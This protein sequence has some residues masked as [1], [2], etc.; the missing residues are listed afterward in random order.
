M[1]KLLSEKDIRGLGKLAGTVYGRTNQLGRQDRRR[2]NASSLTKRPVKAKAQSNCAFT[3]GK[4]FNLSGA[5]V[6]AYETLYIERPQTEVDTTTPPYEGGDGPVQIVSFALAAADPGSDVTFTLPAN[7][8]ED[9]LILFG[10][11]ELAHG[12]ED[13]DWRKRGPI[14]LHESDVDDV[15]NYDNNQNFSYC[16]GDYPLGAALSALQ[17]T[18]IGNVGGGG[19]SHPVPIFVLRNVARYAWSDLNAAHRIAGDIDYPGSLLAEQSVSVTDNTVDGIV[20]V[21]D[22]AT[23]PYS[24]LEVL[25]RSSNST[26]LDSTAPGILISTTASS[27]G[28]LQGDPYY[29]EPGGWVGGSTGGT[30]GLT[31]VGVMTV[32]QNATSGGSIT[33]LGGSAVYG[34]TTP[35]DAVDDAYYALTVSY[36]YMDGSG[37]YTHPNRTK[38]RKNFDTTPAP[39]FY[40]AATFVT[41][42]MAESHLWLAAGDNTSDP[43]INLPPPCEPM[44]LRGVPQ[45]EPIYDSYTG[46]RGEALREFRDKLRRNVA[47]ATVDSPFDLSSTRDYVVHGYTWAWVYVSNPN[48]RYAG[49]PYMNATRYRQ[50]NPALA[51]V[52]GYVGRYYR[53]PK[54]KD[55]TDDDIDHSQFFFGRSNYLYSANSG[56]VRI[57]YASRAD[58]P[59]KFTT[60]D[61]PITAEITVGVKRVGSLLQMDA[62][63]TP[64]ATFTPDIGPLVVTGQDV[65]QHVGLLTGAITTGGPSYG[66]DLTGV[67]DNG[68][69]VWGAWDPYWVAKPRQDL[70][71]DF[72]DGEVKTDTFT[73]TERTN[74]ITEPLSMHPWI[75]CDPDDDQKWSVPPG[76]G[77]PTVKSPLPPWPEWPTTD[78]GMFNPNAAIDAGNADTDDPEMGNYV[79]VNREDSY[80]PYLGRTLTS[81]SADLRLGLQLCYV[82]V[83]STNPGGGDCC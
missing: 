12:T 63:T 42:G 78:T 14:F 54:N 44:R 77:P 52:H 30:Q 31:T 28:T 21:V 64:T 27:L 46:G 25:T 13:I 34:T 4:G 62:D 80:D 58:A 81:S 19:V 61:T 43:V 60:G 38:G 51:D 6:G 41:G 72:T 8:Q 67:G 83:D 16:W 5:G 10:E 48:H 35:P 56:P 73:F 66:Y 7:L 53:N 22:N 70:V 2:R 32:M 39:G 57:I 23:I 1:G 76:G 11:Y 69:T 45:E 74:V 68:Y 26:A 36:D 82:F 40:S 29:R 3:L 79:R 65:I 33:N 71:A 37:S 59:R 20:E 47:I 75:Y 15:N 49:P 17:I 9:D 24:E 55:N 50:V 18:N